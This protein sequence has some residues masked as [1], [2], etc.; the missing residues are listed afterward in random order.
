MKIKEFD[1]TMFAKKNLKDNC[2]F[3]KGAPKSIIYKK[4]EEKK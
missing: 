4:Y 3:I 2:I 1:I